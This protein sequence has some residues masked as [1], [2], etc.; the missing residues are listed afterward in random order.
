MTHA[1]GSW[2]KEDQV[3]DTYIR[4]MGHGYGGGL[5]GAPAL[6]EFQSALKGTD[7]I[8]HSRASNLYATLDNDDYFSYG[9]SIALGVRRANGGGASP[10]FYVSDLRRPGREHHEPLQRF[11]GQELRARYL[12]PKFAKEMMREGYAG[13]RDIWKAVDYLWGWQVVYPETVDAAKWQ[14]MH[15]VWVADRNELGIA[16]FF[17]ENNPYARQGIAA[18]MLEVVRK[19]YWDAPQ[20]TVRSL[21][22]TYVESVAKHGPA[23]DHLSCD[24]PEL[25][26]FTE[27]QAVALG[28]VAPA[29]LERW[30]SEIERAT[31]QSIETALAQRS[32]DKERW[33]RAPSPEGSAPAQAEQPA[34]TGFKMVEVSDQ[35]S[36]EAHPPPP[37][38]LQYLLAFLGFLFF[39]INLVAGIA[40][41]VLTRAVMI[42]A[43][44]PAP[45]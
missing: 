26:R 28:A 45:V 21:V 41:R 27:Q 4:R 18:R 30:K 25:Q 34:V 42:P 36:S 6:E 22:R 31:G 32:A 2:D 8:V 37:D 15:D 35:E 1:S 39:A 43:S 38:A 13:A 33:H 16:Q 29:T 12:N 19:G 11:M 40:T 5:W 17:E 23:C 3:A 20:E 24:N 10:P 9:G 44:A 14:E 7:L